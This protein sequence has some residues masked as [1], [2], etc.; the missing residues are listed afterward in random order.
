MLV[1]VFVGELMF[2]K[3]FFLLLVIGNGGREVAPMNY[4]YVPYWSIYREKAY[5]FA[6]VALTPTVRGVG[7][8]F[9]IIICK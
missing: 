5:G 4:D 9:F 3:F 7:F 1:R 6:R 8:F 2:V